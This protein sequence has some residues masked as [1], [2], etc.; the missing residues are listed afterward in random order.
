MN[1]SAR[2]L[3]FDAIAAEKLALSPN[4]IFGN[5][6][7]WPFHGELTENA[8]FVGSTAGVVEAC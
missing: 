6:L 8:C 5:L 4:G 3:A 2:V 1:E 7:A